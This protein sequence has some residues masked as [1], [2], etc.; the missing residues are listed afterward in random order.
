MSGDSKL[1]PLNIDIDGESTR[2]IYHHDF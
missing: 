2:E 1:P